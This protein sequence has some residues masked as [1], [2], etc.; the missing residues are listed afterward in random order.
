MDKPGAEEHDSSPWWPGL[1][2][3]YRRPANGDRPVLIVEHVSPERVR[4]E[5]RAKT[6]R[7][8]LGELT[9]LLAVGGAPP[10]DDILAALLEREQAMSTGIGHGI[11]IPHARVESL[12]RLLAGYGRSR[13]G[14]EFD[15]IDGKPTHLFFLC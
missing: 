14:I 11:A 7:E 4:L 3:S 5:G 13:T 9:K 1:S 8:A 6:K 10:A 2:I 12:D 15:S